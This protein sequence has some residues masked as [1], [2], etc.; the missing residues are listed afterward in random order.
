MDALFDFTSTYKVFIVLY[1]CYLLQGKGGLDMKDYEGL[2]EDLA[3]KI[4][5]I[6]KKDDEKEVL[7]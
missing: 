2:I 4:I 1:I 5:E 6:M 3:N 7:K